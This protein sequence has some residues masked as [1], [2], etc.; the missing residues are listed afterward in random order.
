M[1]NILLAS[2]ALVLLPSISSVHAQY[3][4]FDEQESAERAE[5]IVANLKYH[6]PQIRSAHVVMHEITPTD[7]PGLDRGSFSIDG[8][9]GANFLIT[10][11]NTLYLLGAEPLDVG[12]STDEITAKLYE[13]QLLAEQA[14]QERHEELLALIEGMPVRGNPDA[15]V[16]IVEF[17]DFQCPYCARA[18]STVEQILEKYPEDIRLVY[19]HMPLDNHPWAMPAAVAAVCA[20]RQSPEA[21]WTLHDSYFQNQQAI[22]TANVLEQSRTFLATTAIDMNAWSACAEDSS[23]DA[24]RTA[25]TEVIRML[26]AGNG[27]GLTG[28]PGFFING[29]F[30]NGAQPIGVFEEVIDGILQENTP[31]GTA[32]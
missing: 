2:L 13:E 20:A 27:Y 6:I 22:T 9:H 21:F 23:S 8:Q 28:T 19:L 18:Y 17:S 4:V 15:P 5:M 31:M 25:R 14:R 12:L 26:T 10:E 3:A 7:I 30:V 29:S 11:N 16:T 32:Q 24:N 1:K